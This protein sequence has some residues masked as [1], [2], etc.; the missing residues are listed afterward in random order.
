MVRRALLSA[1]GTGGH[2]FPAQA[3]AQELKSRG[4][5]IHLATDQRA[6]KFAADFAA[7]DIHV[8]RSATFAGKSPMA[9][10]KTF[11]VLAGGYFASRRLIST[12]EPD[13]AVGFGGYPT[14]PPLLA[15][16]HKGVPSILHEQNAVL[17]RA[18]TFLAG[19][20][21]AL[22][23][24]F[25]LAKSEH[26][27]VVTGN[28]LREIVHLAARLNYETP[29]EGGRL[30]LLVFGGSQGARFFSQIMCEALASM[31]PDLRDRID[32]TMQ[33]REE[34]LEP[35]KSVLSKLD[36]Q[37]KLAPFFGDMPMRIAKSHLVMCRSGASSVSELALIGRPAILVPFPTALDDD[38]GANAARLETEGGAVLVRQKDMD[39]PRLTAMLEDALKNPKQL[40]IQAANAKRAGVADASQ[41]LANLV[42]AQLRVKER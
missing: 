29:A 32:L 4:W 18:N 42:E 39:A 41:R 24:G 2:L 3:L 35:T 14:V 26:K 1:G 27:H 12:I 15:A 7:D 34:E 17:G 10:V 9:L 23:T 31:T 25:P 21:N 16:V 33:T 8:I 20:V 22:A 36:M 11:G 6:Q 30:R 40:A 28:P 5:R 13:V 38:Q 19:R 37:A